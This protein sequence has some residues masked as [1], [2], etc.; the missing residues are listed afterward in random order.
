M[1]KKNPDLL[2]SSDDFLGKVREMLDLLQFWL[3]DGKYLLQ[4]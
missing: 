3:S 1:S 4:V 2:C